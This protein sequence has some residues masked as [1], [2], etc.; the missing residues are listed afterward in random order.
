MSMIEAFDALLSNAYFRPVAQALGTEGDSVNTSHS[1]VLN[2]S[3]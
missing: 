2:I 1:C 3:M